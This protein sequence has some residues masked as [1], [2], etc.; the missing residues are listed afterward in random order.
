MNRATKTVLGATIGA[1]ALALSAGSASADIA[2]S[3]D[4][5]WHV[6]EKYTYPTESRVVVHEDSWKAGP[7]V[8]F[9]EH[10]GRGYWKGETW[11]DIK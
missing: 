8:R 9:H 4:V 6:K 3:G 10:E 7:K 1:V 5:C 2:C 11:I